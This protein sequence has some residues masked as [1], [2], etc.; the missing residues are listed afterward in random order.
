[1]KG[2][3]EI[4]PVVIS[5]GERRAIS[6]DF[7]RAEVGQISS[8]FIE[9][10]IDEVIC[11]FRVTFGYNADVGV[12]VCIHMLFLSMVDCRLATN[13]LERAGGIPGR[14]MAAGHTVP[15]IEDTLVP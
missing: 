1:M 2:L 13:L 5:H 14:L 7:N 9:I 3:Q 11:I 4:G 10:W 15:A 8:T 12:C 6:H